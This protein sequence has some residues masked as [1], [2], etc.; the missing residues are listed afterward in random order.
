MLKLTARICKIG[1]WKMLK[2]RRAT[3]RMPGSG[4]GTQMQLEGQKRPESCQSASTS[5]DQKNTGR[6]YLFN[7]RRSI[8]LHDKITF[9]CQFR[10]V[11]FHSTDK[12]CHFVGQFSISNLLRFSASPTA[13]EAATVTG[14]CSPTVYPFLCHDRHTSNDSHAA[15]GIRN[16]TWSN[17]LRSHKQNL[18][19]TPCAFCLHCLSAAFLYLQV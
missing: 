11:V 12:S 6:V 15:M 9:E 10:E 8:L 7:W 1:G 13:E 16:T 4:F 18:D 14:W 3:H 19:F 17:S 5:S 2:V